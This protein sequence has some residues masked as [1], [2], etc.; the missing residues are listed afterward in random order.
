MNRHH[1]RHGPVPRRRRERATARESG[2]IHDRSVSLARPAAQHARHIVSLRADLVDE[3]SYLPLAQDAANL[4][5]QFG[6]SRYEHASLNLT[7]NQPRSD[8]A[9]SSATGPSPRPCSPTSPALPTFSPAKVK[10]SRFC[11]APRRVPALGCSSESSP[12]RSRPLP[13]NPAYAQSTPCS[14]RH[15]ALRPCSTAE[16]RHRRPRAPND[17]IL[18]EMKTDPAC[19][20]SSSAGG[21]PRP[22]E[23]AGHRGSRR[24]VPTASGL[25]MVLPHRRSRV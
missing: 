15:L 25:H 5:F 20:G 3:V 10:R 19:R 24:P 11:P 9:T 18:T 8:W 22:H 6:S 2:A 12:D 16:Q 21:A 23:P 17:A 13:R 4:L 1:R 7:S 14:S